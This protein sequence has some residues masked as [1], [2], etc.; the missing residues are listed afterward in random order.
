MQIQNEINNPFG[1][2]NTS[3]E[4]FN[5]YFNVKKINSEISKDTFEKTNDNSSVEKQ[6]SETPKTIKEPVNTTPSKTEAIKNK[7]L[8]RENL[9]IGGAGLALSSVIAA[10]AIIKGRGVQKAL[11]TAQEQLTENRRIANELREQ[12]NRLTEL[13]TELSK[14]REIAIERYQKMINGATLNYD[15]TKAPLNNIKDIKNSLKYAKKI[16]Q[17]SDIKPLQSIQVNTS[18]I[19]N[20]QQLKKALADNG[21]LEITLPKTSAVKPVISPNAFINEK[22]VKNLGQ[23]VDSDILLNYGRR[24]NW[25]EQK[26]ARDIMQNFYDGHGNT[27]DG[28]KLAIKKLPNGEFSIKI[29]G[30]ATYDFKNLQFLGSG[31]KETNPFNA[32]GF[33][34][35]TKVLVANMLGKGDTKVVKFSCANWTF[36]FNSAD[37]VVRRTLEKVQTPINGN[38]IEFTTSNKK[39]IDSIIDSTNYFRHSKNPDFQGLHF[40]SPNFAFRFMDGEA[41]GN[42]YLT[43]RFEFGKTGAWD[44]NVDNLDIIFKR[45]PD[46][47]KYKKLIG[48]PFAIDRDRMTLSNSDIKDLTRYFTDEMTDEQIVQTFLTTKPMW[49]KL[50]TEKEKTALSSFLEGLIHTMNSRKIKIDFGEE[51]FVSKGYCNDVVIYTLKNYGYKFCPETFCF[52]GMPEA[53]D[54]FHL[55]SVHK[56]LTPTAEEIKKL[57]M[58]EEGIKIIKS[59]I[60][61]ALTK[62][63]KNLVFKFNP[64]LKAK[65]YYGS[66]ITRYKDIDE[67]KTVI[68]KYTKNTDIENLSDSEF[69]KL[70]DEISQII[71]RILK[72]NPDDKTIEII[73]N[74]PSYNMDSFDKITQGYINTYKNLKLIKAEDVIKPRYIFDR[75]AEIAKDTLGEAL[76]S[77]DEYL[78]H[79]VD[80]EYLK[81]ADYNTILATW[82]H[83]ICH[84]SGGDGTPEFTYTLTDMLRVLLNT[85][86]K[87]SNQNS[88]VKLAALE[89][90]YNNL[91]KSGSAA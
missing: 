61:I 39:L 66:T 38:A 21:V 19:I 32:G 58:L 46:P 83:E 64:D 80:R 14:A 18:D 5:N 69:T 78:G 10:F 68:Y 50:A 4:K 3:N 48:K 87:G 86:T 71:T 79:W 88:R 82:L 2:F 37:G 54:I 49:Q 16:F 73:L 40:D 57:K 70:K 51:K 26:I 47:V 33:G 35:G 60:D 53:T 34:E 27:L 85:S 17:F 81:T 62:Y 77:G 11:T 22:T 75:N 59:D 15:P 29:S 41:K 7:W 8:T 63:L 43:Q 84:K 76:I 74:I 89:E 67:I 20:P 25:S 6:P 45:K 28:V 55:L 72:N 44:G 31:T 13:P 91:V 23:T 42:I 52:T 36:T 30:E 65:D 90:I 1:K 12:I 56:A 24:T 9:I